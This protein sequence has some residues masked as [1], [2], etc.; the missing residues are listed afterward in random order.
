MN[1]SRRQQHGCYSADV[2]LKYII[3]KEM[4]CILFFKYYRH[5]SQRSNW[6]QVNIVSGNRLT[7][8][9]QQTIIRTNFELHDAI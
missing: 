2:I 1:T 3:L 4:F 8:N 7:P 6:Q 9:M 5:D